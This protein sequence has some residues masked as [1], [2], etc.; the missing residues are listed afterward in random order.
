MR[1]R[2][3][4]GTSAKQWLYLL[5]NLPNFYLCKVGITGNLKNRL[6]SIN[7]EAFGYTFPV[8]CFRVHFAYQIEQAILNVSKPFKFSY[9]QSGRS[10]WRIGIVVFLWPLYGLIFLFSR[11]FILFCTVVVLWLLFGTDILTV[12][13]IISLIN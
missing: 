6:R 8:F 5:I 4:N 7:D 11:L 12:Q 3:G 10:E 13:K 2:S 1:K 9:G